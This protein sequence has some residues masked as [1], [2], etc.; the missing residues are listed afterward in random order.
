MEKTGQQVKGECVDQYQDD[1]LTFDYP[2]EWEIRTGSDDGV[3]TILRVVAPDARS[4][5]KWREEADLGVMGE[6]ESMQ[7]VEIGGNTYQKRIYPTEESTKTVIYAR[8]GSALYRFDLYHQN[9]VGLYEME[10]MLDSL[11]F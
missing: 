3:K 2:C 8:D 10:R 1:R 4:V 11:Q 9:N 7:E 6:P 5:L